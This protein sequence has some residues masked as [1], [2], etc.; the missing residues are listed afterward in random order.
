MA[1]L[2]IERQNQWITCPLI[3]ICSNLLKCFMKMVWPWIWNCFWGWI[4]CQRFTRV[5]LR[6]RKV[7][8]VCKKSNWGSFL[9]EILV[10]AD[11]AAILKRNYSWVILSLSIE[12]QVTQLSTPVL[13]QGEWSQSVGL[14]LPGWL[15]SMDASRK[16]KHYSLRMNSSGGFVFDKYKGWCWLQC[17]FTIFEIDT[18]WNDS[19]G[20]CWLPG[21]LKTP[22]T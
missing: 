10:V 21:K 4:K 12:E 15:L 22:A 8:T 17:F 7:K 11:T 2:Q 5:C 1:Y 14:D 16:P 13:F 18:Y 9:N 19:G 6:G 20:T 3:S